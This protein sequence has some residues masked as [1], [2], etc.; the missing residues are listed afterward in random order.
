MQQKEDITTPN[1]EFDI[2]RN[3]GTNVEAVVIIIRQSSRAWLSLKGTPPLK[4]H[5]RYSVC[6]FGSHFQWTYTV[7]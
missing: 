1:R 3:S 4:V 2:I 6:R 7:V 5:C